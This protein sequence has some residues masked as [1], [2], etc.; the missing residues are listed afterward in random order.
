MDK[1]NNERF[2]AFMKD[3]SGMVAR[4]EGDEAKRKIDILNLAARRAIMQNGLEDQ[5][6]EN[7]K[8]RN[9]E[10]AEKEAEIFRKLAEGDEQRKAKAKEEEKAKRAEARAKKE[11]ESKN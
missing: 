9:E 2:A 5:F 1:E 3:I 10:L 4:G 7:M 11:A 8:Q 6:L